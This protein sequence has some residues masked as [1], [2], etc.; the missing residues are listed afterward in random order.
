MTAAAFNAAQ[1]ILAAAAPQQVM[2]AHTE[3][4]DPAAALQ[5]AQNATLKIQEL[6]GAHG[7]MAAN[8]PSFGRAAMGT[9]ANGSIASMPSW[10][11]GI[12][13][14]AMGVFIPGLPDFAMAHMSLTAFAGIDRPD[15]GRGLG[16]EVTF[17]QPPQHLGGPSAKAS[18]GQV[19]APE[20][21]A[22]NEPSMDAAFTMPSFAMQM[23]GGP[24]AGDLREF[25]AAAAGAKSRSLDEL[26][27]AKAVLA[28]DP[29]MAEKYD[30][31]AAGVSSH[32]EAYKPEEAFLAG[33]K[34]DQSPAFR[35]AALTLG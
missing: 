21:P 35:P 8:D 16:S 15:E 5:V 19:A 13:R 1:Q 33:L 3:H 20:M 27:G 22:A 31:F 12:A 17:S 14:L 7:A 10:A 34:P 9:A 28:T 25:E 6:D 29:E 11:S 23:D 30:S 4:K 26:D 32:V 2:V 24:S 18:F